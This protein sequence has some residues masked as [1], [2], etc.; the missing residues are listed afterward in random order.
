LQTIPE[1][2]IEIFVRLFE[3]IS[4]NFRSQRFGG[5]DRGGSTERSARHEDRLIGKLLFEKVHGGDDVVPGAPTKIVQFAGR[6]TMGS[7]GDRQHI[8]L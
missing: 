2:R 8:E 4:L 6:I 1:G 7:Q 3:E 5:K